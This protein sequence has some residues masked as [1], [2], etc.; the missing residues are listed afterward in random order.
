MLFLNNKE[1]KIIK[2]FMLNQGDF[3]DEIMVL[4]WLDGSEVIARYSYILEDEND[5]EMEDKNYEEF[6]SFA[7]EVLKITGNPPIDITK[8]NYF[9][10]SYHNFPDEIIAKGQKIN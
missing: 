7:F 1:E 6:W 4:K 10:I 3:E 8:H 2:T 9:L 5:Y